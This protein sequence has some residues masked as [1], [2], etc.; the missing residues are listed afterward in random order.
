MLF[1]AALTREQLMNGSK[2]ALLMWEK[3]PNHARMKL[4]NNVYCSRCQKVTSAAQAS[5]VRSGGDL[6]INGNCI[7]CD[8]DVTRYVVFD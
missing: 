5:V 2:E 6:L 7:R 3:I 4:L 8:A 1:V